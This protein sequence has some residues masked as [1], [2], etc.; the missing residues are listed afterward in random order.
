MP[1]KNLDFGK[2]G[3]R[4]IKGSD[5]AARK[6][7]DLAGG[8]ATPIDQ[9]R[10]LMARLNYLTKT[11]HAKSAARA[12]GLTV[13]DRTL[14]AW[15]SGKRRPNARSLAAIEQAYRTVRRENVAAHLLKR[16]NGG[17]GTRVEF[18]PL[19][20]SGVARPYQRALSYRSMNVRHWD[21]MVNAWAAGD[22]QGMDD[23]WDDIAVDL[24]SDWGQMQYVS[25]LGFSA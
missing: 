17:G 20:Q 4:G 24:G 6:L 22:Q 7:D 23:A 25:A 18:H 15:T 2:Y 13:T 3:A 5:A 12:A 1:D 19:N 21:A 9:K 14:K 8:I 16:L 11:A 10:G